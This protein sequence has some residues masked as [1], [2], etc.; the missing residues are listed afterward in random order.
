MANKN[1]NTNADQ[2]KIFYAELSKIAKSEDWQN[3]LKVAKKIL[4]ISVNDKKAFHCK[5]VCL[6]QLGQFEDALTS[7]KRFQTESNEFN[8][9]RAYCEYRLNQIENAL[10]TLKSCQTM[11]YKEKELLAQVHYRLEQHEESYEIYRDI[12]KT[13]QDDF[14]LNRQTNLAAVVCALN[15][16]KTS[17]NKNLDMS[18]FEDK[19][20]ELCY[21]SACLSIS[22][23]KYDEAKDKLKKAEEMCKEFYKSEE[24]FD[25]E[26]L[27]NELAIIKVQL[28]YCL[29]VLNKNDEALKIYNSVLKNK[30]SD[31]GAIA[32]ASNNIVT[33]NN[34]QNIFDSKKRIKTATSSE[35]E[36]KL[37]TKQHYSIA[38]NEIL[39]ALIANQNDLVHKLLEQF[40]KRFNES[41]EYAILKSSQL[42]KE[43]RLLDAEKYLIEFCEANKGKCSLNLRYYLIQILVFENKLNETVNVFKSIDSYYNHPDVVNSLVLL[44]NI[45][46]KP[47][48]A[49]ELLQ[50]AID[51][52]KK[53]DPNSKQIDVYLKEKIQYQIKLQKWDKAAE[54]LE[55]LRKK[56]PN[57]SNITSQLIRVYSKFKPEKAKELS[58]E[59]P[60]F[61]TLLDNVDINGLEAQFSMLSTRYGKTKSKPDEAKSVATDLNK[62]KKNKKKKKKVQLPKNIDPNVPIDAERWLPLRERS[63]YKDKR[64][65]KGQSGIGK[66]TQ[67]AVVN[68]GQPQSPKASAQSLPSPQQQ[69][70]AEKLAAQPTSAA[71]KP[72]GAQQ[73]KPTKKKKF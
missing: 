59:L 38:Y 12:I 57:D 23:G 27:E 67:G 30:P 33:L 21:N 52:F 51:Y 32:V 42:Y 70:K 60:S 56:Y 8:F 66:G 20:Y 45:L 25:E 43:K 68:D 62:K 46:N 14:D 16:S 41:E 61:E 54:L 44:F 29:Q 47:D 65:K 2:L 22:K 48:E 31:L 73:K 49:S 7:I 24:D 9:E 58:S 11:T 28:A 5:I 50:N 40:K 15:N 18:E 55:I 36:F 37:T 64:K 17:S 6:I 35:L 13:H 26:E 4:G 39:L 53:M 3:I 19:T 63:Y 69:A 71:Q 10:K 1:P 34:D 72:K